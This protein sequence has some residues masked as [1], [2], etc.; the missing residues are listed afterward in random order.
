MKQEHQGPGDNIGR[1]KIGRQVNTDKYIENQIIEG[2]K[3]TSK[4]LK[5]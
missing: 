1:D 2:E 3:K 5:R 4:K